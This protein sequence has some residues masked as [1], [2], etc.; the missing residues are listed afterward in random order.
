MHT[1][2]IR[3]PIADV[4]DPACERRVN[5]LPPAEECGRRDRR[6]PLTP[7][8]SRARSP[9]CPIELQ[10]VDRETLREEVG[11][12]TGH[13]PSG[14][15]ECSPL[16]AQREVNDDGLRYVEHHASQ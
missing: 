14:R 6:K 13:T 2:S 12:M 1:A 15:V 11:P 8:G 10:E 16:T 7:S 3:P 4:D 9:S 5:A